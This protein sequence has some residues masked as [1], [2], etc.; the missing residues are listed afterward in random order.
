M[1]VLWRRHTD[2]CS[3]KD[4]G[5]EYLKCRCSIWID[6]RIGGKR[7]RKPLNTRD[8]QAA[9]IR[10]RQMEAEGI[11]SEVVP[12]TTGQC[13]KRF[14]DDAKARGLRESTVYKYKLILDQ[15]E[16]FG[17]GAGIT[18]IS[19]FNVEDL[20]SFRNSWMNRGQSAVKKLEH[21]KS[22]FR[23]CSESA[24]VKDNPCKLIRPP[25]VTLLQVLPFSDEEMTKILQA[26]TTHPTPARGLQLR[27]LVLLMRHSGLRIG[28]AVSLNRDRIHDGILELYTAKS[29]TKVRLPLKQEA[30]D[31]LAELPGTGCYFSHAGSKRRN[32]VCAWER[33]FGKLFQRAGI[34][35]H[36]HR[37]RH[38]FAIGLLQRGVS[39]EN[40]STLL[41]HRS[42]KVTERYYASWVAARQQHLEDAVRAS[43]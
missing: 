31:A 14:L 24:W 12:Q 19:G 43:W 33:V 28:D 10:A 7:I 6:W 40:V 18:F 34:N 16:R 26:C 30:V 23:F 41:G 39:M 1:L 3:H 37:L 20:H 2:D 38:T 25:K 35:G 29:G 13:T 27:A 9:Q 36:S 32:V 8:W 11:V 42:I 17:E 4:E 21:L 5:R 15:L 22:F